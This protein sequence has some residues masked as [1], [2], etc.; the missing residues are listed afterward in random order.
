MSKRDRVAHHGVAEQAARARLRDRALQPRDRQ[1]I[2]AADV[3]VAAARSRSRTPAIV[4]AST[5]RERILFHQHAVLERARLR[6]VG[7]ADEVVRA[8]RL[9]ARP[10]PTCGRSETRRRRGRPASSPATSRMHALGPERRRRA[11]APRSRRARGSRRGSRDRPGRRGGAGAACPRADRAPAARRSAW[12]HAAL[13]RLSDD[14][15]GRGTRVS[16]VVA[17]GPRRRAERAP[18]ARARTAEARTAHPGRAAVGRALAGR[19]DRARARGRCLRASRQAM[20]SQT[21]TTVAGCG[22]TEN[23]A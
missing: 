2:L 1:R 9:L 18:P 12:R 17:R 16:V 5:T 10:P 15:V 19:A 22:S 3:D 14:R 4:I 7:V 8:R 13:A 20:S 11:R 6:L 23:I 21:W